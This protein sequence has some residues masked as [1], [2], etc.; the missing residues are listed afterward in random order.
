M[1]ASTG[2][3]VRRFLIESLMLSG[4]AM[5][6][7]VGLAFF[8]LRA[9]MAIAPGDLQAIGTV[10]LDLWVLGFSLLLS[11]ILIG[12]VFGLIPTVQARRLDVQSRLKEGRTQAQAASRSKMAVRRLLVVG[13]LAM[14]A[15]LLVSRRPPDQNAVE[16]AAG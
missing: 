7:G 3:L 12:V 5:L 13:Q 9:L 2:R 4:A 15:M 14:A 16:P 8:G 6:L 10:E 1:G 11:A